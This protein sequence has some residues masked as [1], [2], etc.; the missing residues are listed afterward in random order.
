MATDCT[1]VLFRVVFQIVQAFLVKFIIDALNF[2]DVVFYCL[3]VL[4]LKLFSFLKNSSLVDVSKDKLL[5]LLQVELPIASEG[6][7]LICVFIVDYNEDFGITV[8]DKLFGFAKKSS[9][10]YIECF[11]LLADALLHLLVVSPI[12]NRG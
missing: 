12:S 11:I 3:K 1:S 2:H 5:Y 8:F 7:E 10:S 4:G 9:L 6:K